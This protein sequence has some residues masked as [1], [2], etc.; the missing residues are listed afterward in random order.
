MAGN[1]LGG[2]VV[3]VSLSMCVVMVVMLCGFWSWRRSTRAEW[4]WLHGWASRVERELQGATV[5]LDHTDDRA[6]RDRVTGEFLPTRS[7]QNW[8]DEIE[9]LEAQSEPEQRGRR[10][11]R[12]HA[13]RTL[14]RGRS[15]ERA[16]PSRRW[17]DEGVESRIESGRW[18]MV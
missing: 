12:A 2:L 16:R 4:L 9:A 3:G 15:L 14:A 11:R 10:V 1:A 6:V 7:E 17:N 8:V 5:R 13:F 18:E